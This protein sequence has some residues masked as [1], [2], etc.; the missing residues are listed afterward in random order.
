MLL[1]TSLVATYKKGSYIVRVGE[2]DKYVRLGLS[3]WSA[4][5]IGDTIL[6]LA[7]TSMQ[8]N[9]VGKET[10]LATSDLIALTEVTAVLFDREKFTEAMLKSP[11]A[12]LLTLLSWSARNLNMVQ[13]FSALKSNC[14][15]DI[16]LATLL[17][18][19]GEP[20]DG[21][22]RKVPTSIPQFALARALGASREE[23]SRKRQVLVSTGYL[24]KEGGDEYL[25]AM[26]PMLLAPLGF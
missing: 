26:T 9:A 15:L 25:D 14:P 23:V 11:P 7:S 19:L 6:G 20:A 2:R 13:M 24:S 8:T 12:G 5:Q 22:R 3:G 18:M 17:W 10:L 21:G 16:G 4:L 1:E